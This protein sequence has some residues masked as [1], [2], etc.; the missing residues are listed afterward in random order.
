MEVKRLRI[1]TV[2]QKN[3]I[4][5]L[6]KKSTI[7]QLENIVPVKLEIPVGKST[8]QRD[9]AEEKKF[10]DIL[11][12]MDQVNATA[13]AAAKQAE[14]AATVAAEEAAAVAVAAEEAA[15]KKTVKKARA[16]RKAAKKVADVVVAEAAVSD[17]VVAVDAA[18]VTTTTV[19]APAKKVATAKAPK[20]A[21]K[22]RA[23]KKATQKEVEPEVVV[24][25]DVANTEKEPLA[26]FAEA[27]EVTVE[28]AADALK[29]IEAAE[30]SF[31]E[32]LAKSA[33]EATV[34]EE[35]KSIVAKKADAE[36]K[37]IEAAKEALA[38][39]TEEAAVI[40]E[41]MSI[42]DK[43]D[44][45]EEEKVTVEKAD[46]KLKVIEAAELSFNEALAESTKEAAVMD[47]ELESMLAKADA[48]G[49][50]STSEAPAKKTA[51]KAKAPRRK[52]GAAKAPATVTANGAANENP[53]GS[54][55]ESTLKRKTVAQLTEYLNERKVDVEGLSKI[56]MVG[57]IQ[58][59]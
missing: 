46:E 56:D 52:M 32:A 10:L 23:P 45:G 2:E 1:E 53:W 27:E 40:E 29:V 22:A 58:K 41:L 24:A 19:K 17:V 49:D 34:I 15:A 5:N 7:Q 8:M 50:A 16:P 25:A 36:L 6:V 4:T 13:K 21:R 26:F 43:T 31:K 9:P 55:K 59:L 47:E 14:E 33:K 12:N 20:R 37:V 11:K 18:E 44:A 30:V 28:K 51:T 3:V 42:L 35:L 38:E 48:R 54:L 39:S 57:T